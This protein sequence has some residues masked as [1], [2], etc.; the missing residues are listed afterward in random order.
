[1]IIQSDRSTIWLKCGRKALRNQFDTRF[2]WFYG[3]IEITLN[4]IEANDRAQSIMPVCRTGL[5][6]TGTGTRLTLKRFPVYYVAIHIKLLVR[7][8]LS[9]V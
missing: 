3:H 5:K 2:N 8:C 9:N 1:M 4:A 6:F 7:A